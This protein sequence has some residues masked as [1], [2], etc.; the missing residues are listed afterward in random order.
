M[1]IYSMLSRVGVN[2]SKTFN[3]DDYDQVS[4]RRKESKTKPN[5]SR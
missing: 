4:Y 3:C 2:W 1:K 5:H